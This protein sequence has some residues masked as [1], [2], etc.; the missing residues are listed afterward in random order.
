MSLMAVNA[1]LPAGTK[2]FKLQFAPLT[3]TCSAV[4]ASVWKT[5]GDSASSTAWRGYNATGTTDGTL[6]SG[7]PPTGGDLNLL[8][9]DIAGTF[10]EQNIAEPNT[11]AVPEGDEIEYDWLIEQNGATAE[12][13]YCFRM[14]ESDGTVLDSYSSAYPQIR[15]AS[16]TP[17]TQNWRWYD[18]EVSSTPVVPLA[19][20]TVTPINITNGQG[21]KLRVTVKEVKNISRDDVRFKLQFSEYADFQSAF[22]VVATTSCMA[23]STWCYANGGGVDN[24][25][26]ASSTLSDSESCLGGVGTG[27]GT[28][29]ESP[30]MYYGYRHSAGDAVEYEFT[31]Q[32]AGPRVN[33]VYYFRLYDITQDVAVPTNDGESYPSLTTEGASLSFAMTG[34]AS[35]TIVEGVTLDINTTPMTLSFGTLAPS[36]TL[37][38]AHRLAVDTDGTEGYQLLMYMD[39]NLMSS[40]GSI[41]HPITGTNASPVAW[42]SGCSPTATSCF[43]YHTSDDTLEGGSTRFS[44]IDTYARV[45]TSTPEIVSYSTQPAIGDTTDVIY[46]IIRRELQEAGIYEAH[47]R[48]ISVPMF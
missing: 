5:L 26:I 18:D 42:T 44:A 38:G 15:T 25:V 4:S 21:L 1:T 29:N 30:N 45:N 48:Y 17:R 41:I 34:I 33:R 11:Y 7:N 37:E 22:D 32:S 31:V 10:E 13:D 46:R 27:C 8:L 23:T 3:T 2:A 20:E 14:V 43:G 24:E 9:S 47:I 16:F 6:L 12:T 39:G 35:S 36:T 19:G 40:S 28:R